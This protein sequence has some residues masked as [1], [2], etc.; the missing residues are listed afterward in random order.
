MSTLRVGQYVLFLDSKWMSKWHIIQ[1][2]YDKDFDRSQKS[3]NSLLW[4]GNPT[5]TK[6]SL[7]DPLLHFITDL[8]SG[9]WVTKLTDFS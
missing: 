6:G 5:S 2:N 1:M 4:N 9:I 7:F 8:F 3:R